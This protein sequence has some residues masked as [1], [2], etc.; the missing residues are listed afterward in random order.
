MKSC[1]YFI[2]PTDSL[3]SVIEN[4]FHQENYFYSSL[5]NSISFTNK[6]LNQIKKLI[7][8]KGIR[9]IVFVLSDDNQIVLDAL[10]KQVFSDIRGLKKIYNQVLL[11]KEYLEMSWQIQNPQFL[12][13]SSFLNEKI[14]KLKDGL[15][16]LMIGEITISGKV[17]SK[18]RYKFKDIYSDL[19]FT[20]AIVFS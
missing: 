11:Q 10:G 6:D 1:L 8:S 9:K 15:S 19:L 7:C 13:L 3:E 12:I 16:D 17:Y 18:E 5:G 4:A 14:E 2:C 20:E